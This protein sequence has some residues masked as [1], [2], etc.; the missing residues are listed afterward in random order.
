MQLLFPENLKIH[1]SQCKRNEEHKC[2]L[3]LRVTSH[4]LRLALLQLVSL[5]SLAESTISL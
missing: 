3:S 4:H 1:L 5:Q 2:V